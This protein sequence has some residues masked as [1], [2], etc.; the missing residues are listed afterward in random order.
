MTQVLL[1]L[2]L[3]LNSI[4]F[5]EEMDAFIKIVG[6]GNNLYSLFIPWHAQSGSASVAPEGAWNDGSCLF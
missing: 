3:N 1:E 2:S 4:I 6:S 5:K